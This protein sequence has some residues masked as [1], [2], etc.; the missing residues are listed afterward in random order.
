MKEEFLGCKNVSPPASRQA[1]CWM[2]SAV[3]KAEAGCGGQGQG[4]HP[5]HV[6]WHPTLALLCPQAG[7]GRAGFWFLSQLYLLCVSGTLARIFFH[8][9]KIP[10]PAALTTQPHLSCWR[11]GGESPWRHKYSPQG[12][13]GLDAGKADISTA[14]H[15]PGGAAFL[16]RQVASGMTQVSGSRCQPKR[17]ARPHSHPAETSWGHPSDPGSTNTGGSYRELHQPC[18]SGFQNWGSFPFCKTPEI[19]CSARSI[20]QD[21][22]G[23]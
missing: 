5:P 18:D 11:G 12:S 13:A 22:C 19:F 15:V 10:T 9:P 6:H 23:C 8:I 2:G 1:A 20:W 17:R 14:E 3:P 7:C 4:W 16:E 21:C